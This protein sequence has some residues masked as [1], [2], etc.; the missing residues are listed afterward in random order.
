MPAS[1]IG[2]ATW[3]RCNA[4]GLASLQFYKDLVSFKQ[5][6]YSGESDDVS[7]QDVLFDLCRRRHFITG[8]K[9]TRTSLL[10]GCHGLGP[11]GTELKKNLVAQW[12]DSMLLYREQVLAIDTMCHIPPQCTAAQ[13]LTMTTR[14][15][16][17]KSD[18]LNGDVTQHAG[19]ILDHPQ[20][21][22]LRRDLLYGALQQYASC[23]DLMNKKLPLGLA[24]VGECF[25][26]IPD[27]SHETSLPR[28]GEGTE[29]SLTWFCS[30]KTASQWRDYWLRQRLLWW[31]K[32]AQSPSS[33][34]TSDHQ[35]ELGRKAS[36]ILYSFPWGEE[37]IESLC[38]MDDSVLVQMHS[39]SSAQLQGRDSRKLVTPHVLWA[40]GNLERGLLAYL[41]D[42]L[43]LSEKLAPRCQDLRRQVLKV[44]P[45]LAPIK[46]AVDL[47]KGPAVDLRLVCQGLS[48][49]L[50]ESGIAVWPGYLDTSHVPLEKLFTRF[51][52]M[53]VL[54]TVLVSDG[55]LENG[56]LQLRSRDTTLKETMH[57][58]KV[59]LFLEQYIRAAK[60]L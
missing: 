4:Q 1:H 59:R 57:V 31:Q 25:R 47:A 27:G 39:G 3:T 13:L 56:L 43:Q 40:S 24:E 58:S 36:Q 19:S 44:H 10:S 8:D 23:L 41:A 60:N 46:V 15:D 52:E 26:P 33:F 49:E 6:R 54:F 35:D 12:W 20:H 16:S 55:T 7:T 22:V 5:R 21:R 28:L 32:F 51:D 42:A 2:R 17:Q 29:A 45:A 38:S 18:P 30:A 14:V 50:R 9:L 48:A 34:S 53:G 11:L 37:P